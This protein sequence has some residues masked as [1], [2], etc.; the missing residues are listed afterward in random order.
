MRFGYA[1]AFFDL[2]K[3]IMKIID[4]K[5]CAEHCRNALKERVEKLKARKITPGL[6]VVLVGNNPASEVYVKNKIIACEKLGVFS[7]KIALKEETSEAELLAHI[8]KLNADPKIHGILVQLP[9]PRQINEEAILKAIAPE[10]DVDGFHAQNLGKLVQNT[11]GLVACTPKGIIRLLD[12]EKIE[13]EGKNAVVIGRSTI[14]GKPLALLLINRGATVTVCHSKTQ[15]LSAH[16]KNADILIV[17]IGC[18]EFVTAEMV[19]DGA[20]VIDVG[21]NR[22]E[23]GK[24]AGDVDFDSVKEKASA[25]TPV[26]GGVGPMTIAMLL[27]NTI[28]AAENAQKNLPKMDES[29]L[30]QNSFNA[31]ALKGLL[32]R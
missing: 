29:K 28:A 32:G 24:L 30:F 9:L 31:F 7:Q 5:A 21:I 17:A 3:K 13:I 14:V 11:A 4:G 12:E 10:K 19:K 6:A 23:N 20:V 8:K 26:P 15:N 2:Q 25:I 18:A 27:E 16:T 1:F 22:L